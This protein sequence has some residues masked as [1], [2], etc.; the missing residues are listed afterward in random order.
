VQKIQYVKNSCIDFSPILCSINK[1]HIM[2][3]MTRYYRFFYYYG[4]DPLAAGGGA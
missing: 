3:P 1:V 2:K 4:A